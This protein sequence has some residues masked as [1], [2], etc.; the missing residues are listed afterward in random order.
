MFT[1][2]DLVV[3]AALDNDSRTTALDDAKGGREPGRAAAQNQ[4]RLA[5]SAG[6]IDHKS[7][8]FTERARR[9]VAD[10]EGQPR[11]EVSPCFDG[12]CPA[13]RSSIPRL[14]CGL[15]S[16]LRGDA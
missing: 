8:L 6:S 2:T 1:D 5:L 14:H 11:P 12:A 9:I 16:T 4:D 13:S 15:F 10:D 7:I 3:A